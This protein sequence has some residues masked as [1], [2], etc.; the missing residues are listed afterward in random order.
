MMAIYVFS[1]FPSQNQSE[2]RLREVIGGM[3]VVSKLGLSFKKPSKKN[4]SL[5]S[6]QTKFFGW[7]T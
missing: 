2:F 4:V 1:S 7:K 3:A 5:K 6:L